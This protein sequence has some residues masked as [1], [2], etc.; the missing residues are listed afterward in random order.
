M[1][2][3]ESGTGLRLVLL[4]PP[5]S[6]KG[7]QAARIAARMEIPAISTGE[8][9][10]GAVEEGSE[11]GRRVAAVLE[12]GALVDDATMAELVEQRLGASDAAGGFLLD[13]YPRTLAQAETLEGI[14]ER[15]GV[16][17]DSVILIEV[18]EAE[19]VRRSLARQRADDSEEVIRHRQQVYREK[20]EPLIDYYRQRGLL[21]E[22]D[23]DQS[24]EAVQADILDLLGVAA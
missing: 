1:A 9:L 16:A 5:G 17:L 22:V 2:G 3:A 24:I 7:T 13:G 14:L 20:T 19:L 11:L 10:R 21:R 12:S 23:G 15:R 6:G 4:G 8:M 18:P